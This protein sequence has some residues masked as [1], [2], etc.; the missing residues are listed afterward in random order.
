M[1]S[2]TVRDGGQGSKRRRQEVIAWCVV[3]LASVAVVSTGQEFDMSRWSIDGGGVMRSTSGDLEL[4]GTIGQFDASFAAPKL[5]GDAFELTGGVW[6][7]IALGDCEDDG[8]VD[9]HDHDRFTAC[10]TGPNAAPS[11]ECRCFDVDRNNTVDLVDFAVI[12]TVYTG[13]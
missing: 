10:I 13:S 9:L 7:Q 8:D 5:T 4:S 3:V 11:D 1:R 2:P 6:I 12:Q